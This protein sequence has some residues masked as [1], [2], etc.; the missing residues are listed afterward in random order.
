MKNINELEEEYNKIKQTLN[1]VI[2]QN[3]H[4]CLH[5]EPKSCNQDTSNCFDC[6]LG[7]FRSLLM[8]KAGGH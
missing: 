8:K 4:L 6:L 7:F 5:K 1:G 3:R 2:E